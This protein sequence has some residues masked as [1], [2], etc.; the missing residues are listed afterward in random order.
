M[1]QLYVALIGDA[2][3]SRALP[4]ARR[5]RLQGELRAVLREVNRRWRRAIAAR[6]ALA[7]GDQFEGLLASGAAVWEIAHWV[8][9][10]LGGV[11]WIVA[12][13]RGPISTPL[14]PTAPEVDG[15]CFHRAREALEH[16]KT[17]RLLFAF[18]GFDPLTNAFAAY[19]SALYWGWTL[20]QRRAA[21]LL[22]VLRPADVATRLGV[23]RS[24][25]SHLAGRLG[26]RL[27]AQADT[28]FREV[29]A[30]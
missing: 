23:H 26:W 30:Q 13:G 21:T 1:A 22:R 5:A 14:A 7:L 8:R 4:A 17:R 28:V 19:Y 25:V 15:P 12:C 2:V 6:F 16:A 24:A 18:E 9:A 3:A 11:D 20:R 29:I 27:V 10:E